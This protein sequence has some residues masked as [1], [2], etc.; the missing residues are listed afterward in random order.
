M[1]ESKKL[2]AVLTER[3]KNDSHT[4]RNILKNVYTYDE[5]KQRDNY[6]ND[7][8]ENLTI[9]KNIISNLLKE[10]LDDN[11]N[12]TIIEHLNTENKNLLTRYKSLL[13]ERDDIQSRLLVSKQIIEDYKIHEQELI[14]EAKEEK[15]ELLDQLNRKEYFLQILERKYERAFAV[16]KSK[17]H[18]DQ[19]LASLVKELGNNYKINEN[20]TNLIKENEMLKANL[21]NGKS[22]IKE[23]TCKIQERY[24]ERT[25]NEVKS[26]ETNLNLLKEK[27][28]ELYQINIKLSEALNEANNKLMKYYKKKRKNK[29]NKSSIIVVNTKLLSEEKKDKNIKNKRKENESKPKVIKDRIILDSIK[30]DFNGL[31]TIVQDSVAGRILLSKLGYI[32]N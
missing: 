8:E 23:L 6:I 7:L 29:L 11:N 3:A 18:A 25:K 24:I 9:N 4:A 5:L 15:A 17:S 22:R 16:I 1:K 2:V 12:N 26:N 27:M 13:K 20:T 30:Y 14:K 19:V 31:S 21:A 32:P 10:K 28:E